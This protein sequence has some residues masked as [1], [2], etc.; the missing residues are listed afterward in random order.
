MKASATATSVVLKD[1]Y[2]STINQLRFEGL[3]DCY[4]SENFDAKLFSN[5]CTWESQIPGFYDWFVTNRAQLMKLT[6][7][8]SAQ[9]VGAP[10]Y[11]QGAIESV[12]KLEKLKQNFERRTLRNAVKTLNDIYVSQFNSLLAVQ[13]R[14]GFILAPEYRK[15]EVPI[16]RWHSFSAEKKRKYILDLTKA[17]P[18]RSAMYEKP[19]SAGRKANEVISKR[20]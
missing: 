1:I 12:H 4:D 2:G 16:V 9:P 20:Y 13:N 19:K 10:R 17:K 6:V 7:I 3:V 8:V 15:Y 18:N 5:K 11:Y 14:G